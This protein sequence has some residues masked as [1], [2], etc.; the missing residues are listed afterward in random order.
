MELSLE[1]LQEEPTAIGAGITCLQAIA[2]G[3]FN[4]GNEVT[5]AVPAELLR[6][7]EKAA[8]DPEAQGFV[9]ML[10]REFCDV[11]DE[12]GYVLARQLHD[13]LTSA[14]GRARY[15]VIDIAADPEIDGLLD[16]FFDE[17][18]F[19]ISLSPKDNF[20]RRYYAKLISWSK[21]TGQVIVERTEKTF[22]ELTRFIVSLQIPKHVAAAFKW[23]EEM[24]R[25][26]FGGRIPKFFVGIALAI[27]LRHHHQETLA[28]AHVVF[29][30]FD[31]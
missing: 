11:N 26:L 29:A 15:E 8:S 5:V 7:A 24:A 16:G 27:A 1:E 13:R 18:R 31:P 30:F 6:L 10:L 20:I 17:R 23:K 19:E 25:K 22:T 21:K 3:N 28:N 12:R 14:K 2:E 9:V 4:E